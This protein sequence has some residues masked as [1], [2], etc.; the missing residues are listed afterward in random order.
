MIILANSILQN[1]VFKYKFNLANFSNCK[2]GIQ[3]KPFRL[4]VSNDLS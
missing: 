4:F 2:K 3:N 1:I